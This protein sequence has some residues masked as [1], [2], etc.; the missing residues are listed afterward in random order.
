M[1]ALPFLDLSTTNILSNVL[2]PV[3]G[4]ISKRLDTLFG[5]KKAA[6]APVHG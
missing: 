6:I 5:S 3:T 4:R 2:G 1:I